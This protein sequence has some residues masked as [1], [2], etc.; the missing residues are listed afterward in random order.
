[1]LAPGPEGLPAPDYGRDTLADLLPAVG[2]ALGVAE[3]A[4]A[5]PH[6]PVPEARRICLVLVDGMGDLALRSRS[7]HAPTMRRWRADGLHR[8]LTAGFPTTTAT[9]MGLLGT[10]LTPGGHGLVGYEVLDPDRDVLLNELQWDAAVDPRRWQPRTTLFQR[11]AAAGVDVVRVAPPHF[12]GS[13][14]TEAALRGGR[15]VGTPD[16][17]EARVDAAVSAVRSAPHQLTYLYWGKLD[18]TGHGEGVDSTAW[19]AELERV[20]EALAALARRLPRGT[21]LVVTADHGMVDVAPSQ[22]VDLALEPELSLGVRHA[23]GEPRAVQLYTE[24]GAAPEVAAAWRAR[25]GASAEVVLRS[26]AVAAGWFGPVEERV[27]GRIGDVLAVMREPLAVVNSARMRP[28]TLRLVGQH[29]ALSDL[30]R[31]V[32]LFCVPC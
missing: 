22:R 30:E 13:G 15:F 27:A 20:D 21:L 2:R 18:S 10:G 1:M 14:L 28:A 3:F 31:L 12:D 24:A 6:L 16:R 25:F 5:S 19:V 9:S 11:I 17:L 23:G 29:G 4:A 26:E 32:P 7:G 8:P